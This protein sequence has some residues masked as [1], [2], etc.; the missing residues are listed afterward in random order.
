[1]TQE[2]LA[3]LTALH[4]RTVQ[5]IEASDINVLVTTVQRIQGALRCPWHALLE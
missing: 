4:L 3:E 5:K 2:R 1:M